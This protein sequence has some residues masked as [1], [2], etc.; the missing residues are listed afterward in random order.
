[1]KKRVSAISFY[2]TLPFVYGLKNSE[3]LSE[4]ELTYDYPSL[5]AEKLEKG[6]T[7][8]GIVPIAAI[9]GIKNAEVFT[10]YCISADGPARTVILASECP[11]EE[12]KEIILDYQSRTSVML[13]QV[14][15]REF[16]KLNVSF[17]KGAPG[18]EKTE[19]KGNTAAIVIGDKA[20]LVENKYKYKYDLAEVWKKYTGLPFVFATWV[21]NCKLEDKFISSFNE[22]MKF[23]LNHIPEAAATAVFNG[24]T[25]ISN[26]EYY[27]KNNMSYVLDNR[28]REAMKLFLK[29]V[30]EL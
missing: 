18:Y 2:N 5:I 8:I 20:F 23:G 1:L 4:I 25:S 12:I 6:T 30:R 11:P 17:R 9:S 21:C 3:I 19:I 24:Q 22:A 16:W 29:M 7:D 13:I 27:L 15:A 28:R 26:I 10:N 14:I